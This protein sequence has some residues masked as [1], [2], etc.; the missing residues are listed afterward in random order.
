MAQKTYVICLTCVGGVFVYDFIR[1]IRS[2]PDFKVIIVGV[3]SDA[4]ASGQTLVD[5]FEVVQ[6]PSGDGAAYAKDLLAV[7][8]RHGVQAIIPGSETETRTLA[9]HAQ[10]FADAGIK[11]SISKKPIVDLMTDK[12]AMLTHIAENGQVDVGPFAAVESADDAREA[13]QYLG[14]PDTSVVFK[15]R[16]E[17]GSRGVLIANAREGEYRPLLFDRF[18]GTGHLDAVLQEVEKRGESLK[19]ALAM[20]EYGPDTFD[21]DCLAVHGKAIK[22]IPRLRVYNN[23]LSPFVEGCR[24]SLRPD[25]IDYVGALCQA[26]G[27]HGSCDFDIALDQ[28][29]QPKLLDASCRLSGSVGASFVAGANIPAQLVRIMFEL[30]IHDEQVTDGVEMRP[31]TRMVSIPMDGM[32]SLP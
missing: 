18:C 26:F 31:F 24:V 19:D 11:L 9:V 1:A 23:P 27:V 7:A 21:V 6:R 4:L 14:Y 8:E 12:L 32:E 10:K 20:P 30:P 2:A 13:A 25:V 28:H 22:V 5:R 15:P 29:G 17:T 3:D 16:R